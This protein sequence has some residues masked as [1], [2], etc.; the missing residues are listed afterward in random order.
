MGGHLDGT[1]AQ[2]QLGGDDQ[3]GWR[4]LVA[5]QGRPE[6]LVERPLAGSGHLGAEAGQDTVEQG[7]GPQALEQPLGREVVDGLAAEAGFR[8]QGVD[9]DRD[10][11]SPAPGDPLPLGMQAA[12]V[13]AFQQAGEQALYQ[14]LRG[15][16]IVPHPPDEVIKRIQVVAAERLERRPGLGRGWIAGLEQAAPACRRESGGRCLFGHGRSSGPGPIPRAVGRAMAHPTLRDRESA[17]KP[18]DQPRESVRARPGARRYA[19]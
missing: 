10:P 1:A 8:R 18:L 4:P 19:E 13:V 17:S 6:P 3:V 11:A 9:R 14:V 5:R 15:L 7:Q 16:G 12:E 2:A